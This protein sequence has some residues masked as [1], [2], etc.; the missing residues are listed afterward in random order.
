[1]HV[2]Y[3]FSCILFFLILCDQHRLV[4]TFCLVL[5][6]VCTALNT[7][8][9]IIPAHR[10]LH[11]YKIC[12]SADSDS[13]QAQVYSDEQIAEIID[14]AFAGMDKDNDGFIDFAEYRFAEETNQTP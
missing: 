13:E 1:M 7:V 2:Q 12:F 6:A 5:N 11:E 4:W 14:G 10:S 8:Q 9:R 3:F